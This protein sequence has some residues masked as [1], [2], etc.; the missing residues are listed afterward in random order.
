M[1]GR[2]LRLFTN[3]ARILRSLVL[4][5]AYGR[6]GTAAGAA[7]EFHRVYFDLCSETWCNT[8]WLGVPV[9][10][11]PLDLWIYQEIMAE[12][13]PDLVIETGTADGGSALF[14][15]SVC[16]A[17]GTGRVLTVDIKESPLRKEHDRVEYLVGSSVSGEVVARAREAAAGAKCVVV[18]LDSDHRKPHVLEE[19]RLYAPLVTSGSYMIVEDTNLNGHPVHPGHGPGPM[20]AVEE[21]LGGSPD[22]ERDPSRE[23]FMLT[24]NPKGYLR[25]R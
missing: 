19:L 1:L 21:F 15:A 3:E 6:R 11:C 5:R 10:K 13:R 12:L 23:K 22:F 25:K 20:E 4:K 18:I 17:I 24:F 14:L 2:L 9:Q 8:T 7:R 16:D